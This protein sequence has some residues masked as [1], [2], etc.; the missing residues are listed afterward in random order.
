MIEYFAKYLPTYEGAQKTR[1]RA[2]AKRLIDVDPRARP[3]LNQ[4]QAINGP[5]KL[6]AEKGQ[7]ESVPKRHMRVNRCVD[8][9]RT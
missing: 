9:H 4:L 6:K 2:F 5:R 7:H 3:E 1:L 8:H